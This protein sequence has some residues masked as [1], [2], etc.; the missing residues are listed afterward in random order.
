ML[1]FGACVLILLGWS[2]GLMSQTA[3]TLSYKGVDARLKVGLE[4]HVELATRTKM[5][6]RVPNVAHPDYYD[7]EPNSLGDA[8]VVALPG[9]LPVINREAVAML[10]LIHI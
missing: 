9:S 5:F 10:S 1:L 3:S 6:T 2:L 8:V 4:I 7:A